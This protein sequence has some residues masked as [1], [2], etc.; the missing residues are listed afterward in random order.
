MSAELLLREFERLSEAPGA[1]PRLRRFV[2]N[3]AIRGKLVRQDPGDEPASELLTRI[4]AAIRE[5]PATS[6]RA[7]AEPRKS[8]RLGLFNLPSGWS[9]STLRELCSS[10]TDGDHLP[11]PKTT[12]GVPFLVIGN[13]R[14]QGLLS[15]VAG[16]CQ[17]IIS[18]VLI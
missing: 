1:V 4:R 9:R 11:P 7:G 10:V 8:T 12:E 18:T 14:S 3:L 13:V 2:L 5:S 17:R 16:W 15:R 6:S